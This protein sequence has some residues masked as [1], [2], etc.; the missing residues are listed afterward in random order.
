M[1]VM[2][3]R[4]DSSPRLIYDCRL[5]RWEVPPQFQRLTNPLVKACRP[6]GRGYR[7]VGNGAL[8]RRD[9]KNEGT[10]GDVYENT[11]N[12]DKMSGDKTGIYTKIRP[13][14]DN[15]QQSTGLIDRR[16]IVTH[17]FGAKVDPKSAHQPIG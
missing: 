11:Q 14:H 16:C 3:T 9:V 12:D 7:G 13:F 17:L 1:L 8:S 6:E 5:S 2:Q 10:T 4:E 15:R